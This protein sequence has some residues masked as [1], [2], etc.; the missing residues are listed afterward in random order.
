MRS[1]VYNGI[2]EVLRLWSKRF[3]SLYF[4]RKVGIIRQPIP[5]QLSQ[6]QL[7]MGKKGAGSVCC[8]S[9]RFCA[10]QVE[11]LV[12][13]SLEWTQFSAVSTGPGSF[14]TWP[15]WRTSLVCAEGGKPALR[16]NLLIWEEWSFIPHFVN[17]PTC[18]LL[19]TSYRHSNSCC[20]DCLSTR[21]S[22]T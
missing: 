12:L 17:V 13:Q 1:G 9:L 20:S 18:S 3:L 11:V 6:R 8:F 16:L 10:E 22:Y 21:V 2:F 5:E 15:D 19:N 14:P 4:S 7:L